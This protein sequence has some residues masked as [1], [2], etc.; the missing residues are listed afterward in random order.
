MEAQL[1]LEGVEE[2]NQDED[3]LAHDKRGDEP[4]S[5]SKVASDG[6]DLGHVGVCEGDPQRCARQA[7]IRSVGDSDQLDVG[8]TLR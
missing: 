3:L 1:G 8:H 7:I 6:V 4:S 2:G 5:R